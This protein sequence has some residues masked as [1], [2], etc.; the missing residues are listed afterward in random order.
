MVHFG[1]LLGNIVLFAALAIPGY[2]LGKMG[3]VSDGAMASITNILTDVAMPALVFSKLIM[4]DI[5]SLGGAAIA[6]C[7][8]FPIVIMCVLY[9]LCAVLFRSMKDTGKNKASRFCAVFPN[10]GFLGI[11]LASA[12]FPDEPSVVAFVSLFNVFS[13]LMLLTL[14]VYIYSGDR[15]HICVHRVLFKPITLAVVFGVICSLLGLGERLPAMETYA[16][17]LAALTTPLAMIVLGVEL[18]KLSLQEIF[19]SVGVYAVSAI[20]L[21]LSPLMAMGL[22]L[23]VRAIGVPISA[24]LATALMISTGVSTAASAPAMAKRYGADSKYAAMLTLGAT[25]LCMISLPLVSL[26]FNMLF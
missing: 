20:K 24:E 12:M 22:L 17:Y 1:V 7:V 21:M 6:C 26:L 10:C 5:P 15:R 11:P 2:F 14:G 4:T 13:T 9:A 25:M 3:R 18:S 23:L 16:G 8:L 19:G